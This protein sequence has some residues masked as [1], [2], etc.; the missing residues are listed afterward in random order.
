[1]ISR[2]ISL[3]AAIAATWFILSLSAGCA[4]TPGEKPAPTTVEGTLAA[5]V[6]E[7]NIHDERSKVS[8]QG[9]L[10]HMPETTIVG[11]SDRIYPAL[12]NGDR[13]LIE[14]E[15]RSNFE[16]GPRSVLVNVYITAGT[17]SFKVAEM[18]EFGDVH[19][20]IRVEISD[21]HDAGRV[22]FGEGEAAFSRDALDLPRAIIDELYTTAIRESV[23]RSFDDVR[24]GMR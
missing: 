4:T 24:G 7:F 13:A 19:F 16:A 10:L 14:N 1:M 3:I 6:V 8:E 22:Q 17:Q 9:R 20:A 12:S 5:T 15:V 23:R 2:F 11:E 18:R 21:E